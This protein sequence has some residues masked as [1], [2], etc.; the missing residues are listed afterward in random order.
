MSGK[1]HAACPCGM[2]FETTRR[3]IADGRGRYCSRPCM[4]KYRTR[5]RGLK[6]EIKQQN[7]GWFKAGHGPTGGEIKPG[8]RRSPKTEFKS[9]GRVSKATEFKPG[10]RPW[11]AEISGLMPSGGAHHAW[12]GDEVGY[13]GL[14]D[15]VRARKPAPAACPSCAADTPLDLCNIS[16]EYKRDVRD[17]R[18]LCRS[19]HF[20]HDR[21]NIP[22][23]SVARFPERKK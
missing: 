23:A 13:H 8:E 20:R 6:Y 3:R 18:Y 21:E 19:C 17:W 16:G 4:Y 9:G 2:S 1:V 22:G 10:Q 7:P 5:P 11:N 14:H 15:W 12:V